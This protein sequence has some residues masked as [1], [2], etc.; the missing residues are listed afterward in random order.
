MATVLFERLDENHD[1]F[2]VGAKAVPEIIMD[3]SS[4]TPEERNQESMGVSHP[5]CRST[6]LLLQHHGQCLQAQ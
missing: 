6:V 2:V 5:V 3:F 1:K 4:I